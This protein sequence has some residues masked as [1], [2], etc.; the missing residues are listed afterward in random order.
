MRYT[1]SRPH[2]GITF[3]ELLIVVVIMPV[4]A[5]ALFGAFSSGLEIWDRINRVPPEE[6]VL[7]F[8]DSFSR[9]LRNS[10]VFADIGFSGREDSVSFPTIVRSA[11]LDKDSVGEA[12]YFFEPGAGEIRRERRDFSHVHNGEEGVSQR[13]ARNAGSFVLTYYYYDAGKNEYSWKDEWSGT[14]P[15]RAVRIEL[16]LDDGTEKNKF[17]RTVSIPAGGG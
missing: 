15:P 3:I 4:I 10:F 7:L 8:F 13:L 9:D 17:I 12:R 11:R 14:V 5:V 16:E 6:D 2:K 1:G